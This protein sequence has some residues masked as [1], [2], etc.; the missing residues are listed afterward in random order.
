MKKTEKGT[1]SPRQKKNRPSAK[2]I[3]ALL[4]AA[5]IL[6]ITVT[7]AAVEIWPAFGARVANGTRRLFGPQVVAQV[8][9]IVFQAQD[10]VRQWQY[11][12]GGQQAEAPWEAPSFTETPQTTE[13]RPQPSATPSAIPSEVPG[14]VTTQPP[15][16]T[17][18]PA[19]T[20]T[21]TPTAWRLADLQAL[22]NL[23]GEGIW[24]P[25]LHDGQDSPVAMRTFL[26]PDPERPYT[27]VAVVAL[28][29][30]RVRLHFVLGFIDPALPDGPKGDGLIPEADRQA[31]KLLAAFNGAFRTANGMYGA[32]ANG[33]VPVPPIPEAATIGIYQNGEIRIGSWG[34]EIEADP[35]LQAWR[36]NCTMI[37]QDG[38]I[39]PKVYNDSVI[40][41]GG[42]IS[43]HIVTRRSA[44]GIDREAQTLYYFAGPA[45]SMPALADS[46]LAAGV[47][48]GMLLDIN[49][50]WV[51]FT[52]FSPGEN[53]L[54]A[55]A[56]LPNDMIDQVDRYLGASP[57][58]FF[59]VTLRDDSP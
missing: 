35:A 56:L 18:T 23:E 22:G 51:H 50:F 32:M 20:V 39:S 21:P 5:A 17:A 28:D 25:Y 4:L 24:Q 16:Q 45:L 12:Y 49:N 36:Q 11:R 43:N 9:S 10:T 53:G 3:S 15:T 41:W 57:V 6:G 42:S 26:Q 2:R 44:I 59:Y 1:L 48:D 46:M 58:D 29:L 27:V 13:T 33:V 31:G 38:E 19:P 54:A 52:A 55:E 40:D 14:K 8:E 47:Y 34:D 37:V 7:V 30:A